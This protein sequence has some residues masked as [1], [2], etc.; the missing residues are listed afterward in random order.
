[1]SQPHEIALG[2]NLVPFREGTNHAENQRAAFEV[3]ERIVAENSSKVYLMTF[4][5]D[6]EFE[7]I[8]RRFHTT[9][10]VL[11]RDAKREIGGPRSL[12][13]IPEIMA[14]LAHRCSEA[15]TRW[16]GFVNSDIIITQRMIDRLLAAPKEIKAILCHRTDVEKPGGELLDENSLR[17]GID[18]M[19]LEWQTWDRLKHTY[20]D[21]VLGEPGWGQGTQEWVT[22]HQVPHEYMGDHELLHVKHKAFWKYHRTAPLAHNR[23]LYQ[24]VKTLNQTKR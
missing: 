21:W 16:I 1:M 7:E 15:G 17:N 12:P 3:L 9:P 8:K 2:V 19:F 13:F 24:Q 23:R 4:C 10:M 5:F 14:Q 11:V 22:F 18:G 20:P 6:H